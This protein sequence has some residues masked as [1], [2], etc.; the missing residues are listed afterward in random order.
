MP[1]RLTYSVDNIRTFED[2]VIVITD[3]FASEQEA[4]DKLN[5]VNSSDANVVSSNITEVDE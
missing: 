3:D 5:E 2:Q 1:Y 4:N